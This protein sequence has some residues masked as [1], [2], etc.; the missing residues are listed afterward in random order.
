MDG[1]LTVWLLFIVVGILADFLISLELG[2]STEF[3]ER[4]EDQVFQ[5]E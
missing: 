1:I 3:K 5:Q 4:K 2:N